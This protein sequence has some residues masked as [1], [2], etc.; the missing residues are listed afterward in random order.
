M[1]MA[2][3]VVKGPP[4]SNPRVVSP[5]KPAPRSDDNQLA[6]VG[7]PP[8]WIPRPGDAN[9]R[10]GVNPVKGA[11]RI[12][13]LLEKHG[14]DSEAAYNELEAEAEATARAAQAAEEAAKAATFW[15]RV[16]SFFRSLGGGAEA[17]PFHLLPRSLLEKMK[18]PGTSADDE[19]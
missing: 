13:E 18:Y 11:D 6:A 17:A 3:L 14:G 12:N 19:I 8:K 16:R 9:A 7:G 2:P 1:V 15:G 4:R 10:S 5:P